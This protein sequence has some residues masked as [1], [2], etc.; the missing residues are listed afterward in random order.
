MC[1]FLTP[2]PKGQSPGSTAQFTR[3]RSPRRAQAF[4]CFPVSL[5][6]SGEVARLVQQRKLA[7]P[8]I[9][10]QRK[11]IMMI[12]GAALKLQNALWNALQNTVHLKQPLHRK[13]RS[14]SLCRL[15]W[16]V[17]HSTGTLTPGGAD[18]DDVHFKQHLRGPCFKNQTWLTTH[19]SHFTPFPCDSRVCSSQNGDR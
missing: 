2:T 13:E 14:C 6:A 19:P 12:P 1:E 9:E 3:S 15:W 8:R 5:A 17:V 10:R 4:H 18:H 11:Q 7:I 16:R